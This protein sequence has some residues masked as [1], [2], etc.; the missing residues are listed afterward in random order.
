M[1]VPKVN[2]TALMEFELSYYHVTVQHVNHY[3]TE[4][5]VGLSVSRVLDVFIQPLHTSRIPSF[6]SPRLVAILRLLSSVCPTIYPE[7]EGE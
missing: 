3:A 1:G 2:E 4:T 6:P 5:S 7:V